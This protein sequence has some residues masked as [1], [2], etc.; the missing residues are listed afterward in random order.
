MVTEFSGHLNRRLANVAMPA[1]VQAS[2]QSNEIRLAALKPPEG[3]EPRTAAAIESEILAS[4]VSAF[5][6][7]MW[8]CAALALASAAVARW[9][10]PSRVRLNVAGKCG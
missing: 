6:L 3:I 8:I 1:D 7:T 2:L 10:I 9:T 4:F 5:R